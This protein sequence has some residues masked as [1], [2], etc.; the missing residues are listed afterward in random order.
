MANN[1]TPKLKAY[2]QTDATG[3]VVSGTPVFRSSKPK[4]GNWKEIP[5]YYRGDGN[6]TTS[7]TTIAPSTTIY[8]NNVSWYNYYDYYRWW[9]KYYIC[10]WCILVNL[11]HVLE[12]E[13]V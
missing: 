10:S 12:Q 4:I 13:L 6:T 5:T 9:S 2:V 8:N 1:A 11:M 7:T 3:R